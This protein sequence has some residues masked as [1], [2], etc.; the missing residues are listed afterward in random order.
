MSASD[1]LDKEDEGER[2]Q[3]GGENDLSDGPKIKRGCTDI[4]CVPLFLA[5]IV[6]FWVII[7]MEAGEGNPMKLIK[8]RDFMGNYCGIDDSE[9]VVT[10]RLSQP[11][12]EDYGKLVWAMNLTK[13]FDDQAKAVACSSVGYTVLVTGLDGACPSSQNCLADAAEFEKFCGTNPSGGAWGALQ[14]TIATAT[15]MAQDVADTISKYTDPSKF[16]ELFTGGVSSVGTNIFSKATEHYVMTCGK[17]CGQTAS[18]TDKYTYE[19]DPDTYWGSSTDTAIAKNP[20]YSAYALWTRLS[21]EI[22]ASNSQTMKDSLAQFQFQTFSADDCPYANRKYCVAMPGVTL[23]EFSDWNMCLP[24]LDM[25][26]PGMDA[27]GDAFATSL[28]GLAKLEITEDISKSFGELVGDVLK[29]WDVF[30]MVAAVSFIIGLIFLVLLRFTLTPVVWLSLV[31]IFLVILGGGLAVIVRAN[32]CADQSFGDAASSQGSSFTQTATSGS[33][34]FEAECPG[35]YSVESK[36]LRD[37]TQICGY[38]ILGIAGLW[39]LIVLCMSCR[40]Q[41][42][43]NI[44]KVAAQF[45]YHNPQMLAV[46]IIESLIA[47]IWVLVWCFCA[48][49]LLS[50]VPADTVPTAS[51][52][53]YSEAY[54]TS[55]K[56]GACTDFWPAGG[57]FKDVNSAD[58]LSS[59]EAKCWRCSTPRYAFNWKF[60]YIFFALLWHNAFFV[61]V[62]YC[63]IAGAVGVWFFTPR[64]D[65]GSRAVACVAAKN[66][67]FWHIGSLAFGS[68]ILAIIQWI[69]WFLRFLSKQAK[70]QKN[71][72]LAAVFKCL[73]CCV[74]CFEKCVQ[75]LNKNAYIQIALL[76]T[77]FCKSAYNAFTLILRNAARFATVAALSYM[78][79]FIGF[80]FIMAATGVGGYFILNAMYSDVNPVC[81]VIIYVLIGYLV[82]KLYMGT[83]GLAVDATLQC[84]IAAE[85]MGNAGDFVPEDLK[86]YVDDNEGKDAGGCCSSC[87]IM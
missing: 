3:K 64:K 36:T 15:A 22:T 34:P 28:E 5:H 49:F 20:A 19:P 63:I 13:T 46:P 55:D 27:V 87:S 23:T 76:G 86:R 35:G 21:S 61:A 18:S 73:A 50:Q 12:L 31:L 45:L 4:L 11:N 48:V 42:A 58:C 71:A 39:L 51:Y 7:F 62:A 72:I 32:Q 79:H 26:V 17:S 80:V 68:C 65:K 59:T 25:S 37:F 44:N 75:Y 70:A 43:I 84:F 1:R 82:A 8:Q 14:D 67:L 69:K 83:F 81:P 6:A 24:K 30:I 54:G 10:G 41:L 9:N 85:E 2:F 77:N 47:I 29:T 53:D 66:A 16:A 57:V 60:G 56:S 33:N 40:I 38:V 74:W 78:V 52:A